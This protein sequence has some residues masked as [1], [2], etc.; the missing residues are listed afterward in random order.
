MLSNG[1][2]LFAGK[3]RKRNRKHCLTPQTYTTQR[4]PVRPTIPL[5]CL[6]GKE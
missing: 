5:S 2:L 3:E 6:R 4:P 1:S